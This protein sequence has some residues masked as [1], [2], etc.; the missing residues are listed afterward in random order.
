M[1]NAIVHQEYPGDQAYS[2][3]WLLS[4]A[5]ILIDASQ[6]NIRASTDR[7]PIIIDEYGDYDYGGFSSTSRQAREAGDAAMLTQAN[8]LEDGQSKNMA[9]PW[10]TADGYWDYADY[11]GFSNTGITL[12]GVVDMYR[13]PKLSYFFL[14]SQR[15]PSVVQDGV[16]S[17][18]VVYIANQWTPTSPT[19][20]RVYGNCDQVSL[21]L[22]DNLVETR[23]P[24]AGT[25]LAHPPF[26][27]DLGT[28]TPGT[29]RADCLLGDTRVSTFARRTPGVATPSRYDRRRPRCGPT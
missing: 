16:D 5:D 13:L 10:F 22:N 15:D 27:F 3:A 11:G 18:P 17:G 6:H 14:Q 29:L 25:N 23:A 7:R 2:A 20:V 19:T 12:C 4:R 1:A 24:D 9:L 28:F 21:F 8:N 26:N